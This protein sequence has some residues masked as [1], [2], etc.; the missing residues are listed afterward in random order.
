MLNTLPLFYLRSH[1]FSFH[2]RP[3]AFLVVGQTVSAERALPW[4]RQVPLLR[5][6][7]GSL[8]GGRVCPSPQP[9]HRVIFTSLARSG[10]GRTR[11]AP[12]RRCTTAQWP[13]SLPLPGPSSRSPGRG[14]CCVLPPSHPLLHFPLTLP[15]PERR[16]QLAMLQ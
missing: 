16:C 4:C 7:G 9:M 13:A 12:T 1:Y 11:L 3:C 5:R 2:W 15:F 6:P 10:S 14:A 8:L